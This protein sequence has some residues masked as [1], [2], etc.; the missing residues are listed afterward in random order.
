MLLNPARL[1]VTSK[2]RLIGWPPAIRLWVVGTEAF[3]KRPAQLGQHLK[4][5]VAVN[6]TWLVDCERAVFLAL[7]LFKVALVATEAAV[8]D[9][10]RVV[11]MPRL[12]KIIV[13]G[14]VVSEN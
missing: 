9:T 10:G 6:L 14:L 13:V 3:G 12:D 8:P 1:R 7:G 4:V 5:G 11:R 2:Y